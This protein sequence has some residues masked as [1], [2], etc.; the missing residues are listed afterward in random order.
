[1]QRRFTWFVAIVVLLA[2]GVLMACSAKYV[3]NSNGLIVVPSQGSAVMQSFSLDLVNGHVEQ[4]N[5]VN[6]PPT[7]GIPYAV[8]LDPTG[9]HAYAI[10]Y[11]NAVVPGVTGVASFSI[12]SD[13][14][15]SNVG[16]VSVPSPTGIAMDSAAKYLFVSSSAG[17]VYVFSIGSNASLSAVGAPTVLPTQPGGETPDASA[18]AVTSTVFPAKFAYCSGF[19]TPTTENLYVADTANYVLLNYSV[20]ASGVLSLVPYNTAATG[21]PTETTPSGVAVDPCN[22]FVYVS[23]SKSNS[24]S[25]YTICNTV[26][27][28]NG[29]PSANNSLQIVSGSPFATGDV[30]GPLTEDAYGNFLYVVDTGSNQI[31]GFRISPGTGSLTLFTGAPTATNL[32]P[33]AIAVRSDDSWL[34]VANFNSANISEYAVTPATGILVPQSPIS[35]FNYPSGVAIH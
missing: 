35:T 34:F 27:I 32:E 13:G 6:G 29:C 4:I 8:I 18:L 21:I 12:A 23:N 30:P 22:R 20:S 1:M 16:T 3:S 19:T 14:K 24:V 31:S 25:A 15:L 28:Q 33:M 10:V 7:P 17:S 5:N 2:L 26:S 9:T 11:N